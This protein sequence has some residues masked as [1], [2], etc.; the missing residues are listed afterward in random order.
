MADK[1]NL[2]RFVDA[3]VTTYEH[4]LAELQGG[5]AHLGTG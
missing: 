5:N 1:N 2:Q 3:Q 4:A